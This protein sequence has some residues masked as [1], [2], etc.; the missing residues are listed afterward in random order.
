MYISTYRFHSHEFIIWRNFIK[1]C[2]T[3]FNLDEESSNIEIGIYV[4]KTKIDKAIR[5]QNFEDIFDILKI[6]FDMFTCLRFL[7]IRFIIW[8]SLD[9]GYDNKIHDYGRVD[10]II[11]LPIH[12]SLH[13]CAG[14]EEFD[15]CEVN[16]LNWKCQVKKNFGHKKVFL[17]NLPRLRLKDFCIFS[18]YN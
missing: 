7:K 9:L 2:C 14:N 17:R 11:Y 12:E 4:G 1:F 6:F 16:F 18:G 15:T 3:N 5:V 8:E 13:I 10:T